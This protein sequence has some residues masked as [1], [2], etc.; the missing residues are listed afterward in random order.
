MEK[1]F[2]GQKV[3]KMF[4]EWVVGACECWSVGSPVDRYGQSRMPCHACLGYGYGIELQRNV[5]P[6]DEHISQNTKRRKE[7][8]ANSEYEI[9]IQ[10][11][12]PPSVVAKQFYFFLFLR[13]SK[14][15]FSKKSVTFCVCWERVVAV[16]F[17]NYTNYYF[18][19]KYVLPDRRHRRLKWP[20]QKCFATK[21][22]GLAYNKSRSKLLQGQDI[23]QPLTMYRERQ[24]MSKARWSK[25]VNSNICLSLNGLKWGKAINV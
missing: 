8:R 6:R 22:G 5:S 11:T 23:S 17:L 9:R 10:K 15:Y 7:E 1:V 12:R 19:T 4:S 21:V 25:K 24:L 13:N 14:I 20:E 18:V 2:Q 16:H 3:K